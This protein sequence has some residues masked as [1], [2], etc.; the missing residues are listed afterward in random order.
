M[1]H[2]KLLLSVL[3]DMQAYTFQYFLRLEE[4]SPSIILKKSCNCVLLSSDK[5]GDH[6]GGP[7]ASASSAMGEGCSYHAK[8]CLVWFGFV[9]LGFELKNLMFARQVVYHLS[10][11]FMLLLYEVLLCCPG[12]P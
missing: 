2:C 5:Q 1:F 10:H 7:L 4:A 11:V 8:L 12:W 3:R 6:M 9:A